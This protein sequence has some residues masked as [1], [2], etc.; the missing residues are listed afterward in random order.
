MGEIRP[1][2]RVGRGVLLGGTPKKE[3]LSV[4][5][6]DRREGLAAR[7]NLFLM[8]KAQQS[9]PFFCTQKKMVKI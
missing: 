1:W 6:S 9:F 3:L 8:E 2:S 7:K 5:T 4:E